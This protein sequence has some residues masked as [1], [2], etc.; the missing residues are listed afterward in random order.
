ME[1]MVTKY[2]LSF[3]KNKRVFIT[4]HTGFKGAWLTK[5]LIM[6]GAKVCGYSLSPNTKPNLFT[7]LELEKED[8]LISI[9]GDVKKKD[10]LNE[11]FFS[12][13]PDIV[14]H[15][16]AQPIV[17]ESYI[18]P[19]E[20]YETNILGTVYLC[21]CVRKSKNVKSFLNITTDKVYDNND[22]QNHRFKEDEKLDGFDPYS[23]SKSCSELI[24][25]SYIKSFFKEM[26][27]P[28]STARAGNVIGG[29]DFSIDRIIPDCV[30]ALMNKEELIIRNPS[31]T[32][33]YQHVFDAL[34][35][36]LLI[37]EK[38]YHSH[39]LASSYNVG[40]DE[41]DIITTEELVIKFNSFLSTKFRYKI[42][43]DNGPHEATFL[44]LDNNL[45]KSSINWIPLIKLN[46]AIR[47][48]SEWYK[49]FLNDESIKNISEKQI[50]QYFEI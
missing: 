36:Y 23:N 40:P 7:H 39:Q 1:K 34:G 45:I 25:H 16:A 3:W 31:S 41:D 35:A 11:A 28:V 32:R 20:T 15:L 2:N 19:V 33:P 50:K 12:F 29:G 5:I 10:Y 14:F 37:A 22:V 13:N 27:I 48:T 26:D 30:R 21:E 9:I 18:S 49:A 6:A 44:S 46:D 38:Q 42:K 8:N 17:R 4:G 24:T 47:L 43:S